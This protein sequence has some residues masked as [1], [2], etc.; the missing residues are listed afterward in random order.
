MS[1]L[2]TLTAVKITS[3]WVISVTVLVMNSVTT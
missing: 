3:V 1:E 2:G